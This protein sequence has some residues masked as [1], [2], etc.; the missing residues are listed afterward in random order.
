VFFIL[1]E[2]MCWYWKINQIVNLRRRI[3]AAL[4]AGGDCA[5]AHF[6]GG[7]G[8]SASSSG[9]VLRVPHVRRE[10]GSRLD[11]QAVLPNVRQVRGVASQGPLQARA[12]RTG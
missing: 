5:R 10:S 7:I 9:A 2:V 12:A 1:R 4:Q 8:P 3:L 6:R 11:R